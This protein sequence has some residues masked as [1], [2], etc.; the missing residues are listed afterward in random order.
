MVGTFGRDA[1]TRLV[2]VAAA[3][4]P[5]SETTGPFVEA[6]AAAKGRDAF[7]YTDLAPVLG[8]IGVFSSDARAAALAR[9]GSGPIPL[10]FT[11]GG[12][13][14]G[15]MWTMDLSLPVA[16]FKSIGNLVAAGMSAGK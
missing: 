7:Y 14:V 1:R 5:P 16:A 12:D 10:I 3:K 15:K 8:L 6:R 2:A 4:A 13:G 11:A 9:M